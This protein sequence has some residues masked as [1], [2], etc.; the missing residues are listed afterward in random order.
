MRGAGFGPHGSYVQEVAEWFLRGPLFVGRGSL[1]HVPLV[2]GVRRLLSPDCGRGGKP[3]TAKKPLAY[4]DV[5]EN[6][7]GEFYGLRTGWLGKPGGECVRDRISRMCL[8]PETRL[9]IG[10]RLVPKYYDLV[11]WIVSDFGL[12]S[13]ICG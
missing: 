9:L 1:Q 13:R 8:S 11:D 6:A 3:V 7:A 4:G 5:R 2:R 10:R 12:V